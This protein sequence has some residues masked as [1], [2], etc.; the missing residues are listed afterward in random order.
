MRVS[1]IIQR[2]F[3]FLLIL[4]FSIYLLT[5]LADRFCNTFPAL[6]WLPSLSQLPGFKVRDSAV[7]LQ[8]ISEEELAQMAL[9]DSLHSVLEQ[10]S[11][12]SL[13]LKAD[14]AIGFSHPAPPVPTG[15]RV[16]P[17]EYNERGKAQLSYFLNALAQ[18][19]SS[20]SQ[21]RILHYG[22]SQIEGDRISSYIRSRLQKDFGGAGVGMLSAVPPVYPPYGMAIANSSGW[23]FFSMMP[24]NRRVEGTPYGIMG[25]VCRITNTRQDSLGGTYYEGSVT[26]KRRASAGRGM[27]FSHCRVI[28]RSEFEP[29]EI[30]LATSDSSFAPHFVYPSSNVQQLILQLP[31]L[32]SPFTLTFRSVQSPEIFAISYENSAGIQL[33]NLPLRGSSGGDFSAVPRQ[34][35]SQMA[36]MLSPRLVILQFGVNVVPGQLTSYAYYREI[37]RREI[38]YLQELMPQTSFVLIGVSDMGLK[39]GESFRSYPNIPAVRNAQRAAAMDRNIAFWDCYA[40]MGGENSIISWV[41]AASP[42]AT[43]DYVHFTPRGA[44]YVGEMFYASLIDEYNRHIGVQT[45]EHGSE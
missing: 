11:A 33:D 41:N 9:V 42:L 10:E 38:A 15:V 24:A 37:L 40:A 14:S 29:T 30:L 39:E 34:I 4:L 18:V 45:G 23:K 44:R 6:R 27:Q 32:A 17:F 8:Q 22:D 25:S 26:V 1:G 16:Q 2:V 43:S 31:H 3:L 5:L 35:F 19:H 21:L 28:L 7:I 13:K 36:E 20:V 12:D